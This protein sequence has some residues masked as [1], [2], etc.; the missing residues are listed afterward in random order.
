MSSILTPGLDT[1]SP[2]TEVARLT[3]SERVRRVEYLIQQAD[4]ILASAVHAYGQG[5]RIVA[6][7]VLFSGG[8]DSTVLAHLMRKHAT[9]AIHCNTTIGIEET[10]QFVRDTC[11]MWGLPLIEE[12]PPRGLS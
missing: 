7:C 2:A 9:H 8:N 5:H 4:E 6:K 3:W 11:Q 12:V 10:R 1:P